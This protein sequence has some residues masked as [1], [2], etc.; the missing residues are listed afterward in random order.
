MNRIATRW[1]KQETVYWAKADDDERGQQ[2]VNA[3]IEIKTNWEEGLQESID[4]DATPIAIEGT[5]DVDR[6][7]EAGSLLRLGPLT[8]LPDPVTTGTAVT[9]LVE[10]ISFSK[11]PDLKGRKFSRTVTVQ[12]YK[13]TLP[14]IV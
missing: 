6:D 1:L 7:I 14:T 5:I 10:V 4:L 11:I 8:D 9:N 12:K 13:S 3:G 2:T